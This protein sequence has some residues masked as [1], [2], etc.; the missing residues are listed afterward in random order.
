MSSLY[1]IRTPW[2]ELYKTSTVCLPLLQLSET[3]SCDCYKTKSYS[4]YY[5][6]QQEDGKGCH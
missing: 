6:L 2:G 1:R 5:K 3:I 4:K